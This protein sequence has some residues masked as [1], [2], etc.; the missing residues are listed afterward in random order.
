MNDGLSF[1]PRRPPV[2]TM[3]FKALGRSVPSGGQWTDVV[4]VLAC[5]LAPLIIHMPFNVLRRRDAL[6]VREVVIECVTIPMM[7]VTAVGNRPVRGLPN[8][9][10]KIA[11]ALEALRDMWSEVDAISSL[12]RVRI[13]PKDDALKFDHF[14]SGHPRSVSP[15]RTAFNSVQP[16]PATNTR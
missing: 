1:R 9:D 5:S 6:E 10:V 12:P 14:D 13:A 8:L 16:R 11:D 4:S 3:P 2:F 15:Y 7:D